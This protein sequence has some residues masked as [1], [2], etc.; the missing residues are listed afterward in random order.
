MEGSDDAPADEAVA[1]RPGLA[2]LMQPIAPLVQVPL[3]DAAMPTRAGCPQWAL[4]TCL[5][6]LPVHRRKELVKALVSAY[7]RSQAISEIGRSEFLR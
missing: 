1:N 7:P 6:V 2:A 5:G 3:V 4:R